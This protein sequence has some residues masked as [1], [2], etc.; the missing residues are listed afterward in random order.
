VLCYFFYRFFQEFLELSAVGDRIDL[1]VLVY[2]LAF[3]SD[4]KSP[5]LGGDLTLQLE[6][7]FVGERGF[8]TSRGQE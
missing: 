8:Y 4:D 6:L 1:R 3:Q 7:G 5:A 2:D